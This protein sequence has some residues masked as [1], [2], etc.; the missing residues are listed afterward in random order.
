MK[1]SVIGGGSWG[2]AL[3][4]VLSNN[5]HDVLVYDVDPKIVK[6]VN[7]LH[8]CIQLDEDIN[9]DIRAT[10]NIQ[11]AIS[12]SDVLLFAVPTKVLRPALRSV[13][14]VI[15]RPKLCINA[16]KGI[17]PETFLRVSEIFKEMVPAEFLK[18]FV[19]LSGP[20]HAE[21][22][23][24]G[25]TTVITCASEVEE[26]AI[27]AQHLFHNSDYFR[28]YSS[29][30]LKG[31][32][33]GGALKN[34]FALA[35]GLI[36]GKGL[37]DNARAALIT[38]GLVEMQKFYESYGA[39]TASLFGLTGIGDLIVTCT[40]PHSRNFQAGYKIGHGKDLEE[41]LESMTMVVEGIRT[42]EAAYKYAVEHDL[43]LPIIEQIYNVL[44]NKL[45]PE[46]AYRNLF[47]RSR[48][49]EL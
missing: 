21:E 7:T 18:G 13:V 42:C 2:L 36:A 44:F 48:K 27:F 1:I 40:S 35:S 37:G 20:S 43:E 41:T 23:I 14:D 24:Q 9:D 19:A 46:I 25:M 8:I 5:N 34:I 28:V 4:T 30:D 17:E 26:H 15:E 49:K 10:N 16:A 33:L 32:E 12:F 11:E 22:V 47:E 3:S 29:T 45:D 6:K 31:V 39:D 38:R